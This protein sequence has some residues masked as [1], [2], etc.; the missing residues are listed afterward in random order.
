MILVTH[1][2][3]LLE[4]HTLLVILL[5][6]CWWSAMPYLAEAGEPPKPPNLLGGAIVINHHVHHIGISVPSSSFSVLDPQPWLI[7]QQDSHLS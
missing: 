2:I 7:N 6:D 3:M 1:Q 4:R 5:N